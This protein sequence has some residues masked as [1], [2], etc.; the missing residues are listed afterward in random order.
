MDLDDSKR[1]SRAKRE[2]VYQSL[3]TDERIEYTLSVIPAAKV[4]EMNV[5]QARLKAM[6][7]AILKLTLTPRYVFVDGNRT[8]SG[9]ETT[10]QCTVTGGDSSVSLIAAA[11]IIA[12]VTRD[13]MMHIEASKFPE[14]GFEKHVGYGTKQHIQALSV[15]GPC[16]I[17]RMTY[18]P[19][20]QASAP[21]MVE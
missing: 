16:S 11:S 12:K 20:R 14:Y 18:K 10:Q 6:A 9:I 5:F 1:L 3:V 7:Q 8:L 17:H 4:D 19:I 13:K 21:S 15:Y 2:R